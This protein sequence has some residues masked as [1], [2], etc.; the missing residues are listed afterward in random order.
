[1]PCFAIIRC[2]YIKHGNFE[3]RVNGESDLYFTVKLILS[4][5]IYKCE[6]LKNTMPDAKC[7]Q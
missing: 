3:M 4:D 1:M 6:I 5:I 7:G 2:E